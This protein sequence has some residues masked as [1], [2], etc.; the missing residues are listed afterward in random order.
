MK[1]VRKTMITNFF[2][3]FY[4]MIGSKT[5]ALNTNITMICMIIAIMEVNVFDCFVFFNDFMKGISMFS[6]YIIF[7]TIPIDK[8]II[9]L[10]LSP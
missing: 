10:D 3:P 4:L 7:T 2:L 8:K 5:N 9:K 1:K 6:V